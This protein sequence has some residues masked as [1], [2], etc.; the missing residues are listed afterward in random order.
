MHLTQKT[1]PIEPKQKPGA[2][3]MG[4]H[5]GDIRWLPGGTIKLRLAVGVFASGSNEDTPVNPMANL[6]RKSAIRD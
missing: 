6:Q 1:K 5:P 4:S 3:A 2:Q